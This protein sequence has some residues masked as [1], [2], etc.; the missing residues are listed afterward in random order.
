MRLKN[1][2][3][4]DKGRITS[5][6]IVRWCAAQENWHKVHYDEQ[7]AREIDGL[8]GR[9]INGSLKQEL[10]VQAVERSMPEGGWLWKLRVQFVAPDAVGDRLSVWCREHEIE[11][12]GDF[13]IHALQMEIRNEDRGVTTT[14]EAEYVLSIEDSRLCQLPKELFPGRQFTGSGDE[15]AVVVGSKERSSLKSAIGRL[16]EEANSEYPVEQ[17]RLRLYSTAIGG[18]PSIYWDPECARESK[19]GELV[20]PALF[21]IH[22]I[23]R[24]PT[25]DVLSVK[26]VADGREAGSLQVGSRLTELF[27]LPFRRLLNGGAAFEV[28]A[29]VRVGDRISASAHLI[30]AQHKSG[31]TGAFLVAT[32]QSDYWCERGPMLR[33]RQEIVLR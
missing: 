15:L 7:F 8:E 23:S 29:R 4:L 18:L 13:E 32:T 9:I 17:G 21:P 30:D 14:A 31:K 10:I 19:Y 2:L 28:Y 16:I 1:S 12:R 3:L 24:R 6:H 26:D 22:G 33:V 25:E 11:T 27:H 20:A 5:S